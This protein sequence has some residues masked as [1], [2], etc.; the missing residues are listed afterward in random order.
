MSL[1][2]WTCLIRELLLVGLASTFKLYFH[3]A[4]SQSVWPS[5]VNAKVEPFQISDTEYLDLAK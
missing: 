5:F 2:G 1:T 3:L 4:M